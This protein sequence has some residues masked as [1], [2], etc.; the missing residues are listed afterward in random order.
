MDVIKKLKILKTKY[1]K[2]NIEIVGIFGSVAKGEKNIYSDIDIAYKVDHLK[3][4]KQ[5]PG[6]KAFIKLEDIK[7][8]LQKE[9]GIKV[10]LVTLQS[11]NE[12][13]IKEIKKDMLY[14]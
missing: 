9:L 11:S 8:E 13:F 6:L 1:L 3:F 12:N 4:L 2:E 10:D 7:N 14:V 5:Y